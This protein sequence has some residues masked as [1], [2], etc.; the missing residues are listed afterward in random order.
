[1]SVRSL[2]RADLR[3]LQPYSAPTDDGSLIRLHANEATWPDGD[4]APNRY[5]PLRPKRLQT[6]LAQLFGCNPEQLLLTRGSSEAIDLLM[7]AFCE[8]RTDNAVTHTPGFGLYAQY[9]RIQGIEMRKVGTSRENAFA[10]NVDAL[11]A[12][13]DD[14][15]KLIFVCS[16]NNPTGTVVPDGDIRRLLEARRGRSMVVVD[17]AYIEYAQ[18]DSTVELLQD[19]DNLFVLRTL[20]KARALAGLRCGAVVGPA[21][22][23]ALLD[24]VLP[25]YAFSTPVIERLSDSLTDAWLARADAEIAAVIRERERLRDR[26]SALPDVLRV[27]PSAANFLLIECRDAHEFAARCRAVGILVRQCA[28]PLD[29]CVRVTVG[30]RIDNDRLLTAVQPAGAAV[31]G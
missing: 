31:N 25:P 21:D 19:F 28:E 11:L 2:V 17:E 3:D 30:S 13:C 26:L 1:M 22:G 6:R 16:P 24:A 23:I 27:Y 10:V 20:S 14:R 7:R 8:A 9:A 15:S 29:D 12:N 18:T 4:T 5:P